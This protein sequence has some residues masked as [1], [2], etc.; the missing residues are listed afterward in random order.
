[1]PFNIYYL[2]DEPELCASM[3][4]ILSSSEWIVETFQDAV[5]LISRCENARP[6]LVL[7]D[8]QLPGTTG[9]EVAQKLC[10]LIPKVLITGNL[11]VKTTYQ[12]VAV[13][14]KPTKDKD[15]FALVER[16]KNMD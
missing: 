3:F 9:D 7:L 13:L 1:M 16:V 14:G 4:D 6:D 5:S 8:Y 10:P 15:L 12:F 2:D 11:R